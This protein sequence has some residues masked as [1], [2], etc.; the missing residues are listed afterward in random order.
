MRVTVCAMAEAARVSIASDSDVVSARQAGR[1]LGAKL[2]F[3]S[4][5]LTFIATPLIRRLMKGQESRATPLGEP[6]AA[7]G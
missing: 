5:E 1:A 3:G 6:A 2:G 7:Q 4:A